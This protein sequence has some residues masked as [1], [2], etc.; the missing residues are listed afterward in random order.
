MGSGS[1]DAF[2][3]NY[4]SKHNISNISVYSSTT[5]IEKFYQISDAFLMSSEYEPFG[6]T[7]I[8]AAASNLPVISIDD[9][10]FQTATKEILG[11][12]GFYQTKKEFLSN[13]DLCIN[14][15]IPTR[16]KIKEE[17]SWKRLLNVL[18]NE[19]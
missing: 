14:S 11:R 6:Q 9:I 5:E 16:N 19:E 4:I 1:L 10:G 13:V 3:K 8:E 7:I 15:F 18:V 2:I 17:Y 12:Y